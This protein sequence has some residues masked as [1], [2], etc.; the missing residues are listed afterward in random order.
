VPVPGGGYD[1]LASAEIYDPATG[2]FSP[3]R[4]HDHGPGRTWGHSAH[5]RQGV[6]HWRQ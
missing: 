6:N 2:A 3:D 1:N 5:R 4:H